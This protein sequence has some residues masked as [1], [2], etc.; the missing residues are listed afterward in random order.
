MMKV[1]IADDEPKVNLLLQKIV[2]WES[3]GFQIVGT[4]NDGI[5]ALELIREEQ[6]DLVLT[7]IR[8]P[9][10]DGMELIR[11]AKEINPNVDFV[12]VSGYRQFEYART[13]LRYGV[14]DYLLKPVKAEELTK[15]LQTIREKKDEKLQMEQWKENVSQKIE[16]DDKR[17]REL[18]LIRLKECAAKGISFLNLEETNSE[19]ACNFKPAVYQVILIKPDLPSGQENLDTYRIMM[20]RSHET[21]E[22][23][24]REV[25]SESA[26]A[27][28]N[29]GIF[30]IIQMEDYDSVKVKKHLTRIRKEIENQR[31]LF[32]GIS[33]TTA[34][35]SSVGSMEESSKSMWEAMWLGMERIFHGKGAWLEAE[36]QKPAIRA[37]EYRLSPAW[38]KRLQ[39]LGEYLDSDKLAGELEKLKAELRQNVELNGKM[40]GECANEIIEA[41]IQGVRQ[42]EKV[43]MDEIK[44]EFLLRYH[45]CTSLKEVFE[46]LENGIGGIFQKYAQQKEKQEMRPILEAKK[47]IQEH[48]QDPLKL[49]EV[50][51]VIGFNATYFSTVFKKETGKNFLDYL[52]Q[53]RMNKAKQ[54]LC[55][56]DKSVNDVA[57]E[58]GYQDLKYF[59]KLFKKATGISPSEY[60]KLYQ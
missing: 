18:L 36:N 49:E 2:D 37:E 56:G 27:L 42:N 40:V 43:D 31:D 9:G 33:V 13:A 52:T 19:Y 28:M 15:I 60:K 10:C 58:V 16:K 48:Y 17:N 7:D 25:F 20:K 22:K 29:E 24:S 5:S 11:Q 34:M 12:V 39:E 21:V 6:P 4:A 32:W 26:T 51:R 53:V 41:C 50:S 3:L 46:L 55:S 35:G 14:E 38:R 30:L 54:L 45:M 57:E 23:C 59:S 8:M 44:A 1:I 47:Y